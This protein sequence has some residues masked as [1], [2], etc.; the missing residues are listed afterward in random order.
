MIEDL[1]GLAVNLVAE[2]GHRHLHR[3]R[4]NGLKNWLYEKAMRSLAASKKN[5]MMRSVKPSKFE[6]GSIKNTDVAVPLH[7]NLEWGCKGK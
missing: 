6:A 5:H 3:Y 1:A 2:D 4:E 7:Q